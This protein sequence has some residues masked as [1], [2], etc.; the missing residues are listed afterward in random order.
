MTRD[1]G[2]KGIYIED[3]YIIIVILVKNCLVDQNLDSKFGSS[4]SVS[5]APEPGETNA[6]ACRYNETKTPTK[7]AR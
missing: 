1:R 2:R 3:F 5:S 7:R 6:T 4:R